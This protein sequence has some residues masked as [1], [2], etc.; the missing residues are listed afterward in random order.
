[1]RWV[2]QNLSIAAAASQL[3]HATQTAAAAVKSGECEASWAKHSGWKSVRVAPLD[4]PAPYFAVTA[5]RRA[6]ATAGFSARD[7]GA[8][9]YGYVLHPGIDAH[10]SAGTVARRV[11]IPAGPFAPTTRGDGCHG[12]PLA[13]EAACQHLVL[14]TD[15]PD[16]ALVTCGDIWRAP[17]F[18]RW[19]PGFDA[20]FGDGGAAAV[21]TRRPGGLRI[22]STAAETDPGLEALYRGNMP[23]GIGNVHPGRPYDLGRRVLEFFAKCPDFEVRIR[24]AK[25]VRAAVTR[26]LADAGLDNIGQIAHVV[27]PFARESVLRE[28]YVEVLGLHASQL[29]RTLRLGPRIGHLGAADLL[30]ILANL[31]AGGAVSPGAYVLLLGDG[32]GF[33][34]SAAVLQAPSSN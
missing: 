19:T 30:V 26:A 21:I 12:I 6:L 33:T 10:N 1:M 14:A 27:T 24:M 16:H 13:I 20:P 15:A 17:T 18:K 28:Q 7:V 23:W 2:E 22:R 8:V 25:T 29:A 34:A 11:G 32:S 4:Y 9:S 31:M 3:G 5:G